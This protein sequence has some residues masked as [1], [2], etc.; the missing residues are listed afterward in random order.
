MFPRHDV[1]VNVSVHCNV[2]TATASIRLDGWGYGP[3]FIERDARIMLD[4]TD[5]NQVEAEREAIASVLKS[6]ASALERGE[7]F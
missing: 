6:L 2:A 7:G 1:S 4:D 3:H 5:G